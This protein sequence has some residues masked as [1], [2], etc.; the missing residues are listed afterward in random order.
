MEPWS[1]L[2]ENT[3]TNNSKDLN[4][5]L[6]TTNNSN[7]KANTVKSSKNKG[8]FFTNCLE[9]LCKKK[10]AEISKAE[11]TQTSKIF[12]GFPVLTFTTMECEEEL[13]KEKLGLIIIYID[14]NIPLIKL[15]GQGIKEHLDL[16]VLLENE[17][18]VYPLNYSS[19]E[20]KRV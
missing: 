20:G 12:A 18:C 2:N 9:N 6:L 10:P 4:K 16:L 8:N 7:R 17:Y 3:K 5:P 11:K 19:F 13:Q 15:L 14:S 1:Q